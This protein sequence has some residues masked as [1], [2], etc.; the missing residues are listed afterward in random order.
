M[1]GRARDRDSESNAWLRSLG[2]R[3]AH[4]KAHAS[5]APDKGVRTILDH[6]YSGFRQSKDDNGVGT[7]LADVESRTRI[8]DPR[9]RRTADAPEFLIAPDRHAAGVFR[10]RG[11]ETFVVLVGVYH[12]DS[13][14]K[15]TGRY[16]LRVHIR[17]PRNLVDDESPD[18]LVHARLS[19]KA[20][21]ELLA[22]LKPCKQMDAFWQEHWKDW[23]DGDDF[24]IN[25]HH[26]H[27][28]TIFTRIAELDKVLVQEAR[29]SDEPSHVDL[30]RANVDPRLTLV[31]F[32]PL[33]KAAEEIMCLVGHSDAFVIKASSEPCP[34][35][36][37]QYLPMLRDVFGRD[38]TDTCGLVPK[39]TSA[40][41][42]KERSQ[43]FELTTGRNGVFDRII[44]F[45][46]LIE[47]K[48]R[49]LELAS[50]IGAMR[51]AT[52]PLESV[53]SGALGLTS[54]AWPT[55][56]ATPS[57]VGSDDEAI[58]PPA[59]SSNR[60]KRPAPAAKPKP[61]PKAK[62]KPKPKR[63]D[64]DSDESE[65]EDDE[66]S[67]ESELSDGD[68]DDAEDVEEIG[69]DDESEDGEP[70]PPPSKRR[71][72]SFGAS[73]NAAMPPSSA[74]STSTSVASTEPRARSTAAGAATA[75]TPPGRV[76]ANVLV[77]DRI[78]LLLAEHGAALS[79]AEAALLQS[80]KKNAAERDDCTAAVGA[81]CTVLSTT[82]A[83]RGHADGPGRRRAL[84]MAQL[85]LPR[86]ETLLG[87]LRELRA[88][89]AGM[90][91]DGER[92]APHV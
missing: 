87:T 11:T 25:R 38:Y 1:S 77:R 20:S 59:A 31:A 28:L 57:S 84:A 70:E 40:R 41:L 10:I 36:V 58:V 65:D 51:D 35:S 73:A 68:G 80:A 89:A 21:N 72:L 9:A 8:P 67:E 32:S 44:A 90:A 76:F 37:E 64:E 55:A 46:E 6:V 29:E 18:C 52:V 71:A 83:E 62:P 12:A 7:Q 48:N 86:L 17:A 60:G 50:L 34:K 22:Q 47:D 81:L 14:D 33:P 15:T 82:L 4:H 92:G 91:A 26:P 43:Y 75:A 5:E 16:E 13:T 19:P 74:S 39:D 30:E 24:C 23:P 63:D 85:T 3:V 56:P 54:P 88:D 79:S 27:L 49:A 53:A 66:E 61:K 45:E 69:D 78:N 2:D 42:I